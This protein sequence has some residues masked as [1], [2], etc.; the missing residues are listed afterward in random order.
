[1]SDR[2][3]RREQFRNRIAGRKKPVCS[4]AEAVDHRQ[5]IA[6]GRIVQRIVKPCDRA[7]RVAERRVRS[8]IGDPFAIEIDC[9]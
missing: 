9:P 2:V 6:D 7:R 8:H 3:A 5:Q 4:N 1:M